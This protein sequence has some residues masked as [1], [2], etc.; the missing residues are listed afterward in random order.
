MG[1]PGGCTGALLHGWW[2]GTVA[3][4]GEQ[5]GSGGQA[6]IHFLGWHESSALSMRIH[7]CEP[8]SRNSQW[9]CKREAGKHQSIGQFDSVLAL[10]AADV[11]E[12]RDTTCPD[13]HLGIVHTDEIEVPWRITRTNRVES[14]QSSSLGRWCRSGLEEGQVV[15]NQHCCTFLRKH[16]K[17]C[18]GGGGQ[19][20]WQ[21]DWNS[22]MGIV[23]FFFLCV[24]HSGRS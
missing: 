1:P 7:R 6:T 21:K 11:E 15:D 20:G 13:G 22:H 23:V 9:C 24:C 4:V 19:N 2:W 16:T 5:R 8:P 17:S 12:L 18:H 14:E 3:K 10:C